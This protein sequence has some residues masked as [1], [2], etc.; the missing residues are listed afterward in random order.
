[1]LGGWEDWGGMLVPDMMEL[2]PRIYKHED[3]S[4][5]LLQPCRDHQEIADVGNLSAMEAETGFLRLAE[6]VSSRPPRT[7]G[8]DPASKQKVKSNQG[9]QQGLPPTFIHL[10]AY[11]YMHNAHIHAMHTYV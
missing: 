7:T 9:R 4:L 2:A 11:T 8:Q 3:L 1:M 5:T 10:H 6:P